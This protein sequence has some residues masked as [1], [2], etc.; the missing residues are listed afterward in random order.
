MYA[1]L[2][3]A[4]GSIL[5]SAVSVLNINP[6]TIVS[7]KNL[8]IFIEGYMGLCGLNALCNWYQINIPFDLFFNQ[9]VLITQL[10]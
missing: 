9:N 2:F 1:Y 10:K 5:F 8:I 4:L 3:A 6:L 7:N